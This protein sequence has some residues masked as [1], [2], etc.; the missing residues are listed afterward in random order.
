MTSTLITAQ[1]FPGLV[2]LGIAVLASLHL[3]YRDRAEGEDPLHLILSVAGRVM[4]VTGIVE[5]CLVFL[6]FLAPLFF[7]FAGIVLLYTTFRYLLRRRMALL[8]VMAAAAQ[9]WMP[10]A[11]AV[12][13]FSHECR[14]PLGRRCR[15]LTTLLNDG[16]PLGEALRTVNRRS[17]VS[18]WLLLG[19][20]FPGLWIA[21]PAFIRRLAGPLVPRRAEA[22]IEVGV[23]TGNLS[24]GLAEAVRQPFNPSTATRIGGAIWYLGTIFV[25]GTA[26]LIFMAIKVVPAFIKIFSDFDADLPAMTVLLIQFCDWF[27]TYGWPAAVLAGFCLALFVWLWMLDVLVWLPP[28][29]NVLSRRREAVFVL[30]SL[31]VAAEASQPFEP[32]LAVLAEHYPSLAIRQRLRKAMEQMAAGMPWQNCLAEQGLLRRI[33]LAI[34]KSA[35]RV[36]NLDWALREVAEGIERRYALRIYRYLEVL[37]PLAVLLAGAIVMFI[38]VAL[39]LPVIDLIR[40]V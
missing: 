20:W 14:G 37:V 19:M 28:P 5:A 8:A 25:V 18:S 39:F 30:R 40:Q 22:L 36:G 3:F 13:A 32:V 16:V 17:V 35:E 33:E 21:F 12:E 27:A 9:R 26:V 2:L 7:L 6:N 11:P 31:A 38:V 34:L 24:G 10:L 29:L 4:I 23:R 1:S 15:E